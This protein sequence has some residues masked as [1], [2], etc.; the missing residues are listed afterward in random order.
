VKLPFGEEGLLR[1]D[2]AYQD[3]GILTQVHRFSMT[4]AF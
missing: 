4:M 3:F 1:V 2:Y